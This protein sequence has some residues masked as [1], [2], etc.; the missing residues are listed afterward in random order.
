MSTILT[1][2][3]CAKMKLDGKIVGYIWFWIFKI[4]IENDFFFLTIIVDL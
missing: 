4:V 1:I 3:I 2:R